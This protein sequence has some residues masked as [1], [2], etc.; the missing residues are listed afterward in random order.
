MNGRLGMAGRTAATF[1]D[2]KLTPMIIIT[3][4][5]A[6]VFATI[7]LPREE[8]PQIIVPMIDIMVGAPGMSAKE[9]EQ[10]VTEPMER[11]LW[12]I[13]GVEYV[14]STSMPSMSMVIV[15]YKVGSNETDSV[16]STYN[17]M[18]ANFDLIPA[19]V[20]K[21]LIKPRWIDDVAVLGLT[22]W[23]ERYG[24]VQKGRTDCVCQ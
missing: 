6:G 9:V 17:K 1:I 16:L 2:S 21:P 5:L 11:L 22:L 24:C 3:A 12:E 15:R 8:E 7:M 18:Y 20:S 13:P 23:G 14:Y 4:V 10:R 19:G